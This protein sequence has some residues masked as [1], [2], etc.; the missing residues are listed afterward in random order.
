MN[1]YGFYDTR[2]S[3]NE[4]FGIIAILVDNIKNILNFEKILLLINE[5]ARLFIG[6]TTNINS[7]IGIFL[8]GLFIFIRNKYSIMIIIFSMFH[9]IWE[10]PL[11]GEILHTF[12]YYF[13][14]CL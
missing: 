6:F 12:T 11:I 14:F 1:F 9:L 7:V 8:I 10:T 3:D 2:L 13:L 4:T 5:I